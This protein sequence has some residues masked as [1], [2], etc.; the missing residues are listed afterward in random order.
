[1]ETGRVARH[2]MHSKYDEALLHLGEALKTVTELEIQ[3]KAGLVAVQIA[4]LSLSSQLAAHGLVQPGLIAGSLKGAVDEL[5]DS[6]G[7]SAGVV[8]QFAAQIESLAAPGTPA[9][10]VS[11]L[12]LVGPDE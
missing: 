3:N 7:Q 8:E 9:S 2:D 5:S 4:F 10:P 12:R 1:M 6:L 11:R